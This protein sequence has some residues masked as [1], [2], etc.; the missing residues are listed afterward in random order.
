[1]TYPATTPARFPAV[2]PEAPYASRRHISLSGKAQR[3]APP[4]EVTSDFLLFL[5]HRSKECSTFP[6]A[7]WRKPIN[8][9][10]ETTMTVK[11]TQEK[12][13]TILRDAI[14][15]HGLRCHITPDQG[16]FKFRERNNPTVYYFP[17]RNRYKIAGQPKDVHMNAADFAC[18]YIGEHLGRLIAGNAMAWLHRAASDGNCRSCRE[19]KCTAG[20]LC[21]AFE[22]HRE[23][24][25]SSVTV[26]ALREE[27][28]QLQNDDQGAA[29]CS[30]N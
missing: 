20:P 26:E 17:K 13:V 29:P 9:L 14:D 4:Y 2:P 3:S 8:P 18:W 19:D 25:L 5:L 12:N 22:H 15:R 11:F 16:M 6:L 23:R 28:L 10:N 30:S 21:V 27:Q 7:P 24:P 1:M